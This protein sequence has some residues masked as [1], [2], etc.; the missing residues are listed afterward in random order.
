ML[1]DGKNYVIC[2]KQT[3]IVGMDIPER[4]QFVQ[5]MHADSKGRNIA[6]GD[7][8]QA[9]TYSSLSDACDSIKCAM[10]YLISNSELYDFSTLQIKE[11]N[12]KFSNKPL[13]DEDKIREAFSAVASYQQVSEVLYKL[14]E[15]SEALKNISSFDCSKYLSEIESTCTSLESK[16]SQFREKI[17]NSFDQR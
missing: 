9:S 16:R 10:N 17:D 8:S 13:V 3:K 2:I 12:V 4:L 6:F 14:N 5:Y 11:V 15:V 7:I 1:R